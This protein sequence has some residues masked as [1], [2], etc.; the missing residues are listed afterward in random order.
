[1]NVYAA[2]TES[3]VPVAIII[4][5]NK[6]IETETVAPFLTAETFDLATPDFSTIWFTESFEQQFSTFQLY[7][8]ST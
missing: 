2:R 7:T 4:F 5:S 8:S 3:L 6:S 1:M